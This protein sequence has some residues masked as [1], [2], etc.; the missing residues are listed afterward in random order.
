MTIIDRVENKVQPSGQVKKQ[1]LCVCDCGNTKVIQAQNLRKGLS[2]SC[3]CLSKE[4]ASKIHT[5][6]NELFIEDN[7]CYGIT[8]N[9]NAKFYFDKEDL[10]K[11]KQFAWFEYNGYIAT[12][13]YKL[14]GYPKLLKL[15]RLI[16]DEKDSR[17]FVD[18]INHDKYDNR[19]INLRITTCSQNAM[20]HKLF[21]NN[22]SG[23]S[24]VL[25]CNTTK[26]WKA[27]IKVNYKE[28]QLGTFT[29]FEDAVI[30]RKQAEDRYFREY[31]YD[32][33]I[34]LSETYKIF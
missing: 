7:I 30:A 26:K 5:K 21:K 22:S 20:N 25:F 11:V 6:N 14:E 34:Q 33:S 12:N 2:K 1:Y 27:I 32:N 29:E 9:S 18:H 3:G 4:I 23:V 31:S 17:K 10:N 13:N 19:K 28:I 15:H 16:M 8:T 24:G